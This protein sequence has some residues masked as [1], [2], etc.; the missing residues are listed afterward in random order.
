MKSITSTHPHFLNQKRPPPHL[1]RRYH[2]M[3][4]HLKNIERDPSWI[5][6]IERLWIVGEGN[7]VIIRFVFGWGY[8]SGCSGSG[9]GLH[10]DRGSGVNEFHERRATYS[11]RVQDEKSEAV[12]RHRAINESR[13]HSNSKDTFVSEEP[14]T[15]TRSGY[16]HVACGY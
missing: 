10:G 16:V 4:I 6:G 1:P 9:F 8:C 11:E 2:F 15:D 14:L 12:K 13:K 7:G 3:T 5:E